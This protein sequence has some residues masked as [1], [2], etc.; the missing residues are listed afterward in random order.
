MSNYIQG[1]PDYIRKQL[2]DC[3]ERLVRFID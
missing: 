2:S 1:L 3:K